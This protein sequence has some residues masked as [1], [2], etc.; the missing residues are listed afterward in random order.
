VTS[1][2]EIAAAFEREEPMTIGAEEELMLLD[3]VDHDLAPEAVRVLELLEGDARFKPELPAS[4][5][6]SLTTPAATV[7]ELAAQLAASRRTLAAAVDGVVDLAAAGVH[8]TAEPEGE[9]N[10]GPRYEALARRY[11][12]SIVSRQLVCALQ[13]HVAPGSAESALA[14]YNALRSY[15]P[16][17]AAVAAN[18]P[19]LAGADTG[20][21]SV[22][23]RIA[24]LLPRQGVPPAFSSWDEFAAALEWGVAGE[25]IG[26]RASWWWELR[27]HFGFGTLELRVP[28]AQTTVADAGAIAAF[29]Q[30]LVAWL[31]DGYR[32][33]GALPVHPSWRI[34][35]NRWLAARGGVDADLADLD[36]GHPCPLRARLDALL[37]ELA[38]VA[39][40]L[41]CSTELRHLRSLV[42]RNGAIRQREVAA[43]RGLDG[44]VGWLCGE[45]LASTA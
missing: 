31:A 9:I 30:C 39:E 37:E 26:D 5:I 14:V 27:P 34:A 1:G 28:D 45:F 8:P 42:D 35:E 10:P 43:E 6:E 15:L 16:A 32:E 13:L 29:A 23:P 38:P 19:F 11:G 12:R 22:R 25:V 20:L 24:Q 33:R 17:I 36:T 7:R 2:A 18:A 40:R 21:A 3:P 44:L 4:Q 41:D